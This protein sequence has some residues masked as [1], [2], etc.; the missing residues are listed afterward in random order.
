MRLFSLILGLFFMLPNVAMAACG[1]A[2]MS[3]QG[4]QDPDD[5]EFIYQY[6]SVFNK[7]Q[8]EYDAGN[9]DFSLPGKV[10]ECDEEQGCTDKSWIIMSKNH[11]WEGNHYNYPQAYVCSTSP[12][13]WRQKSL[14]DCYKEW[15]GKTTPAAGWLKT[16]PGGNGLDLHPDGTYYIYGSSGDGTTAEICVL[17]AD[18]VACLADTYG[19]WNG[20]VCQCA[21][22]DKVLRSWNS[23]TKKCEEMSGST[24]SGKS[25]CQKGDETYANVGQE[26]NIECDSSLYTVSGP[27]D[28]TDNL[29]SVRNSCIGKCT[30]NGWDIT[31]K[32]KECADTYTR[33]STHKACVKK[34]SGGSGGGSRRSG[35]GGTGGGSSGGNTTDF[36]PAER[37]TGTGGTWDTTKRTCTC[38]PAK[39]LAKD[40]TNSGCECVSGYTRDNSNQCVPTDETACKN[41]GPTVAQW[42]NNQC[43]CVDTTKIYSSETENC[44]PNPKVTECNQVKGAQW[45]NGECKCTT[46]GYELKDGRECVKGAALITAEQGTSR[47]KISSLYKKLNGM[48]NDF[49]VSVWKN[50]EGNFNTA[51]LA[52]DSIAAVVLGTTGAL[53]TSNIV[54]KNQVSSG[55]EDI[56]CQIGGQTVAGWGDEFS[57]GM[58]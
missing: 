42:K 18:I 10:W 12:D 27:L 23:K 44:V 39:H 11:T 54:K 3:L 48:S 8:N 33:N 57:V 1:T 28:S 7:A 35:G 34:S 50:A 22:A 20:S 55:F 53:V 5:D 4:N 52:S 45:T 6:H 29:K 2:Y 38:D 43:V 15:S 30:T 14:L 36:I 58:Q 17:E 37:C 56:N 26:F 49:K 51:R 46:P 16:T 47:T 24:N 32:E 19:F 40:S 9:K 25:K 13:K 21:N 31:I 41:L